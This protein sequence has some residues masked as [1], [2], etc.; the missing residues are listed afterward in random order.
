M[1]SFSAMYQKLGKFIQEK[2]PSKTS[3]YQNQYA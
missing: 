2:G 1:A 3:G